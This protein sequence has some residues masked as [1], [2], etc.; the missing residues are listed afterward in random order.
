MRYTDFKIVESR[1]L[2]QK[3]MLTEGTRG[4]IGAVEDNQAGKANSLQFTDGTK[5]E[6]TKYWMFPEDVNK[7]Q[8]QDETITTPV[9]GPDNADPETPGNDKMLS[10][11]DQFEEDL[12]LAGLN[13][14]SIVDCS[15]K[16]RE[17]NFAA[18]VIE[19]ETDKGSIF[20]LKYYR[21]KTVNNYLF[22]KMGDFV[23]QVQAKGFAIEQVRK[24]G[25]QAIHPIVRLYPNRCGI[26]TGQMPLQNVA[27]ILR[28]GKGGDTEQFPPEQR[29]I[30]ADFCE[31]LG[32][33]VPCTKDYDRNYEV[34]AGEIVAP[35][36]LQANQLV[37]GNYLKAE[38]ELLDM[39]KPGLK[40]TNMINVDFPADEAEELIDSY[41]ISADGIRV[42]IS[43]KDGG[44]GAKASAVSIANTLEEN[45]DRIEK[46]HPNFLKD[47]KN[48]VYFEY[49][50]I[51]KEPGVKNQIYKLA[52]AT[53]I[54]NTTERDKLIQLL[55]KGGPDLNNDQLIRDIVGDNLYAKVMDPANYKPRDLNSTRYRVLYHFSAGLAK[56][57][58][59]KMNEDVESLDRFFRTILES[60]NMVQV[61]AK[62][63]MQGDDKGSFTQFNVI[64][65]PVFD[66]TIRFHPFKKTAATHEPAAFAF[67]IK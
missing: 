15:P 26:T 17:K 1:L 32:Q 30:V 31:N 46:M 64:Y 51:I 56:L 5:F 61:K 54:I 8:Y 36:A 59:A 28:S 9:P 21:E 55:A 19:V 6:P 4:V 33:P 35:H 63:K 38:Q 62:F 60:S 29:E 10:A 65:P 37:V 42:G 41:L 44:G 34:Q 58:A 50:D 27:A 49:M 43:S 18:L 7:R 12:K 13:P 2:E 3:Q 45:R 47:P 14:N 23:T 66:G 53:D 52:A 67:E 57:T 25:S 40:W 16:P 11:D 20:L 22:W 48:K 24:A 39:L